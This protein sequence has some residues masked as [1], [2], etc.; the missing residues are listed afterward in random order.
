MPVLCCNN[1][2]TKDGA[3]VNFC[4]SLDGELTTL[5]E[6]KFADVSPHRALARFAAQFP[7]AE[8]VPSPNPRPQAPE[9]SREAAVAML[10]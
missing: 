10:K 9:G 5:V 2:R 8:A 7:D 6:C 4:L 1:P 3:E